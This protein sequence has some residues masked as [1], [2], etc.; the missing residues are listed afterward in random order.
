M[1]PELNIPILMYHEITAERLIASVSKKTQRTFILPYQ[2]FSTQMQWLVDNGFAAI[3]L[4]ALLQILAGVRRLPLEKK[5][6]IVITFDDG[7]AGN[8]FYALPILKELHLTA[9]FFVIVNR[10]G[11]PFYMSWPQLAA[12]IENG[13]DVQSHTMT[14]A[15][16]GQ[17]TLSRL[18]YELR[19]SKCQLEENLHTPVDFVSLPHGSYQNNF[20]AAAQECGYA[21]ACTSEIAYVGWQT[22]AYSLPRHAISSRYDLLAFTNLAHC[23]PEFLK[24]QLTA[25]KFKRLLRRIVGEKNYNRAHHFVYNIEEG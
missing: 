7:F 1:L 15:L 14:H 18:M 24:Q 17:A 25:S 22:D 21:G 11:L 8:Y 4:P 13:M 6:I 12:L 23:R 2:A 5:K 3:S 16:L 9:T 10:I 19:E 20:K